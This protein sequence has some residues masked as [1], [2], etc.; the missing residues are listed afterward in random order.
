[1]FR[2]NHLQTEFHLDAALQYSF[3]PN[4]PETSHVTQKLL[5]NHRLVLNLLCVAG[6]GGEF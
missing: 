4:V 6:R 1:M 5:Q 3:Q 2:Q